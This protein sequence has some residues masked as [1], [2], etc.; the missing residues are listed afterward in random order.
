MGGALLYRVK[1]LARMLC[2]EIGSE[3]VASVSVDVIGDY[4][5]SV[6]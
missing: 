3:V 4:R 2:P 1:Q 6:V 5:L